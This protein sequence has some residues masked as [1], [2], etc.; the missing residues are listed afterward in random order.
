[1]LAVVVAVVVG[2]VAAA[3]AA[4]VGVVAATDQTGGIVREAFER[5]FGPNSSRGLHQTSSTVR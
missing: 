5:A 1:M 2:A 4:A 3:G